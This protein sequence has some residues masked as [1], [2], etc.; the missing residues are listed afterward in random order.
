MTNH[1]A[2]DELMVYRVQDDEGNT[3]IEVEDEALA[4]A[5]MEASESEE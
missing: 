5:V 2:Y 4:E 1:L 3:L